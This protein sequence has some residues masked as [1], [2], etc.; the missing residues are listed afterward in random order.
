MQFTDNTPNFVYNF[1]VK[2][3]KI[4]GAKMI[5]VLSYYWPRFIISAFFCIL[6]ARMLWKRVSIISMLLRSIA[7]F[8]LSAPVISIITEVYILAPL[9]TYFLLPLNL[10]PIFLNTLTAV[11][12]I[13][14]QLFIYA[15]PAKLCGKLMKADNLVV[16][17]IYL[18]SALTD[19]F[20]QVISFSLVSYLVILLLEYVVLL[21]YH[22]NDIIF[23]LNHKEHVKWRPVYFYN[24]A[25]FTFVNVCYIAYLFVP[26]LNAERLTVHTLWLNGIVLIAGLSAA[27]YSKLN[28][29]VSREQL[30]KTEY[31]RKFQDN[32]TDIISNFA[33]ISEAKSGETGQHIKRV[34]EYSSI[35]ALGI[36]ED[37]TE[38]SYIRVAS[39]MH[40]IGKLMIPNDIIEKPGKLTKEEYETIKAHSKYGNSLLSHSDGDIMSI[41]KSIAY[42]HHERWDGT[43]YPRGLKGDEISIY[44][45]IVS[46]ADVYDAL[47]SKRS[48]KE[49]WDPIE[50][51]F[52]ILRQR[53]H[54]FSPRIVDNFIKRFDDIELVRTLYAD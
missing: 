20:A 41:A 5:S 3:F 15:I 2:A 7:C 4:R 38:I 8:F 28:I 12:Y 33:I 19:R 31:M 25:Y 37:E 11:F 54:Q 39:M 53:G 40:D 22:R 9:H 47:T 1:I 14:S 30:N 13:L 6:A 36:L 26:E 18:E 16:A 35:L 17:S 45:Q 27:G 32:Q 44:A 46:V 23:I 49:P 48:Y 29:T 51:K 42:E 34:S 10:S 24:F 21:T 52:E 43:G 50:A